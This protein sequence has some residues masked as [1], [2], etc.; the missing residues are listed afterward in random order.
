MD[1]LAL[2]REAIVIPFVDCLLN[3]TR[4][5]WFVLKLGIERSS[6]NQRLW[7][8]TPEYTA[9][10][11]STQLHHRLAPSLDPTAHVLEKLQ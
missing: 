8:Q 4:G 9:R 11:R 7:Q 2:S 5:N 1:V 3:L 6:F 10:L